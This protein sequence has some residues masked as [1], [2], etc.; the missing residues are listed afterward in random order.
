MKILAA[1]GVLEGLKSIDMSPCE[2]CV[3]NKQKRVTFTNTVKELKKSIGTTKQKGVEVELLKDS[4]RDA[5]V[6][7]QE[8]PE[9]VAEEPEVK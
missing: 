3:M 4:P 7:T 8:T 6:D 5:V 2:N 1:N 9:T